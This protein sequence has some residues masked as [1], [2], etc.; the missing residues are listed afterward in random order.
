MGAYLYHMLA[1]EI[2][3]LMLSKF[4]RGFTLVELVIAM[5]I[6]GIL[7]ALGVPN[8]RTWLANTQART[9]AEALQN[10]LRKA[11][12]EAV[13]LNR[14]VALVLT[15]STPNT[16]NISSTPAGTARNWV[17]YSLPLLNSDEG[18]A[19]TAGTST[20][21]QT[22]IQNAGSTTTVTGT[23]TIC[24]SSLGRLVTQSTSIADAGNATC[25]APTNT[26]PLNF[27]VQNSIGDRPLRIQVNLGGQI[28]MCD[29]SKDLSSHP[30]GCTA[31]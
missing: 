4:S 28:R 13:R 1:N 31:T 26:A 3:R 9:V 8:F 11:Q 14:Q 7:A 19:S 10:D 22:Y 16:G 17:L 2:E 20:L 25:T 21:I 18:V 5:T 27:N 6:I 24:F 12:A 23:S 30:D 15:N 29:P